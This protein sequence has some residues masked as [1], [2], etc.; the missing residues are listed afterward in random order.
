MSKLG[1]G[2]VTDNLGKLPGEKCS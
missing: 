1:V 2:A